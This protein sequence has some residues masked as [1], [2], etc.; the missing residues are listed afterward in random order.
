M[1]QKPAGCQLPLDFFE[2]HLPAK[3]YHT[4][5]LALGLQIRKKAQA[6]KSRYV[7]PNGPTHRYWLVFDIDRPDAGLYW[8]QVNAPPPNIVA[9]NPENGHGHIFYALET[10][11]RTAPDGSLSAL[12]YAAAVE[13]GLR[14]KLAADPGYSAL[15]A[16]NP[17]HKHWFVRSW[18]SHLY[19]LDE[20]ASYID[21]PEKSPKRE[22]CAGLGR[23]CDL[24]GRLRRWSYRAIRQGWPDYDRWFEAVLTRAQGLNTYAEPLQYNEIKAT[25]KSVA[26]YTHRK[27]SPEGF[28]AWQ[29]KQ[30]AKGGRVS[31]GGGVKKDVNSIESKRPWEALGISRATYYRLK[32]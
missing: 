32:R 15:I 19:T 1:S 26:R 3:P 7:Q 2:D 13:A 28:S 17:T 9:I 5:D 25:A 14:E 23:N 24:F 10:P 16:K 30:G 20:L 21:L 11:V 8:D 31:K 22:N 27:F 6:L 12:K 29:A 4:D 18:E